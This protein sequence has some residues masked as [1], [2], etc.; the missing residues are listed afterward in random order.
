MTEPAIATALGV[1]VVLSVLGFGVLLPGEV[2]IYLEMQADT[3]DEDVI[4]A[5]GT[6]NPK[7]SG[8]QGSSNS[9]SCS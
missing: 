1:V 7:M 3:P 2:H 9:P 4:S 5:I 6:G 8:V